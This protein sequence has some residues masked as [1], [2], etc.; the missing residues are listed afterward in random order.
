M[1]NVLLSLELAN[2]LITDWVKWQQT[3][4]KWSEHG[5]TCTSLNKG[6]GGANYKPGFDTVNSEDNTIVLT[7]KQQLETNS[8]TTMPIVSKLYNEQG[9]DCRGTQPS[10]V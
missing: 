1:T 6:I 8:N 7:A 9:G 4:M 3:E 2:T 10:S 5:G